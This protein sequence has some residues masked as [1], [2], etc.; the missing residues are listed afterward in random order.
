[1]D[2][3]GEVLES[4]ATKER[5]KAAALKFMKK[6]MKRHAPPAGT[7]TTDGLRSY[8]AAMIELGCAASRRSD[9][10]PTT[11]WRTATCP[12]DDESGR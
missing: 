5:D 2:H 9:A 8:K 6:L 4:F 7:I 1:V 11:G 3:E 10:G 12:F